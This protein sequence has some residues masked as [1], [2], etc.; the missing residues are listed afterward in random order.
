ML[1]NQSNILYTINQQKVRYLSSDLQNNV[2]Y[3]KV[4]IHKIVGYLRV[5][6]AHLTTVQHLPLHLTVTGHLA[7][8]TATQTN[9]SPHP[10][11]RPNQRRARV[12]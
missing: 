6:F 3:L 8:D 9:A 7:A 2:I 5:R 1:T 11:V 12:L 4:L 10:L